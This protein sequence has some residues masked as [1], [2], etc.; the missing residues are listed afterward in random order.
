MATNEWALK[1]L[2]NLLPLDNDSLL[3]VLDYTS[4]LSPSAAVSHL[5]ALLGDSPRALDFISSYNA[6]RKN[7]SAPS[8]SAQSDTYADEPSC[9][10]RS[11]RKLNKKSTPLHQLPER[12]IEGHGDVSGGYR[13]GGGGDYMGTPSSSQ[14]IATNVDT[15]SFTLSET[16][17]AQQLPKKTGGKGSGLPAAGYLISDLP[18]VKTKTSRS[19]GSSRTASPAPAKTKVTIQGGVAG[20]GASSTLEDLVCYSWLLTLTLPLPPLRLPSTCSS[21]L[22]ERKHS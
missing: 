13:K 9:V 20:K 11:S 3:Q 15:N 16:P 4:T 2:S 21:P 10:P 1:Q 22:F 17:V 5:Q 8:N 19:Q 6:R 18:N 7:S 14:A 12:K